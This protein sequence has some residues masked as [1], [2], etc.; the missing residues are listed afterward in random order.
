VLTGIIPYDKLDV[1]DPIAVGVNAIGIKWLAP[2]MNVG[3][4]FGLS[5]VILV[6]LLGQTRIFYSMARDGLLPPVAAM[7]H[8]RYR[9]PYVSTLRNRDCRD[10]ACGAAADRSRWPT[11]EHRHIAGIRHRLSRGAC[12]THHRSVRGL[13]HFRKCAQDLLFCKI[14]VLECVVK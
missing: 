8:P 14:D 2:I 1:P 4:I 9:T 7:V 13:R 5:S 6:V 11:R 10:G 3:I 12:A